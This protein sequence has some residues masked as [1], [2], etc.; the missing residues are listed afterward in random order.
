[1]KP[2]TCGASTHACKAMRHSS[3]PI[4]GITCLCVL[5]RMPLIQRRHCAL[6][7]HQDP[8]IRQKDR[9][10]PLPACCRQD[11][12]HLVVDALRIGEAVLPTSAVRFGALS[13]ACLQPV[14]TAS[15]RAPCRI[16]PHPLQ[17]TWPA[18][19]TTRAP[20]TCWSSPCCEAPATAASSTALRSWHSDRE[21][22]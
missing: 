12:D 15:R 6:Q 1:M 5:L 7:M 9:L 17:A 11:E 16:L 22:Q 21:W 20:P 4:P 13:S 2:A 10:P 3:P 18:T 14:G 19:S 8:S